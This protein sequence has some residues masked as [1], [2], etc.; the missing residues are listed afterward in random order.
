MSPGKPRALVAYHGT[1]ALPYRKGLNVKLIPASIET[2]RR[3]ALAV[4]YKDDGTGAHMARTGALS[5]LL[6]HRIG[7][8]P[9]RVRLIYL[10]APMH[11]VGKIGIP[12]RVLLKAGPLSP[13]EFEVMKSHTTIGAGILS[14]ST[15]D[16]LAAAHSIALCHHERWDGKGY[17]RGLSGESIPLEGRLVGLV[18]AFDAMC[19]PR[20]YR[21]A[22]STA[23]ACETIRA[24]SGRQFDPELVDAF[25]SDVSSIPALRECMDRQEGTEKWAD[26][27]SGVP[28]NGL[29]IMWS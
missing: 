14:G 5:A 1:R 16:L 12:D 25:L 20:P 29:E 23:D 9:D 17:P 27:P 7:L 4:A 19:S 10:A 11:D 15:D 24:L 2:L 6:A 3:L 13:E 28:G 26:D 21:R 8:D 18:D 22:L